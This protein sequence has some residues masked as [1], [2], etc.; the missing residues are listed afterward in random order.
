MLT[1]GVWVSP[2]LRRGPQ[3]Y[4][5]HRPPDVRAAAPEP[6]AHA[7]AEAERRQARPG[8]PGNVAQQDPLTEH[9]CHARLGGRRALVCSGPC[10]P[11]D[12]ARGAP[13]SEAKNPDAVVAEADDLGAPVTGA[14]RDGDVCSPACSRFRPFESVV[15]GLLGSLE[16]GGVAEE[17][18][19]AV[20]LV[21]QGVDLE[22]E[23]CGVGV[24][25]QLALLLGFA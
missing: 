11:P 25:G 24:Q 16:R 9:A 21:E 2:S 5:R 14:V 6:T 4:G 22:G 3:A 19:V 23:L 12:A 20:G 8:T 18:V 10:H 7:V 17:Q 15:D 1:H 13:G